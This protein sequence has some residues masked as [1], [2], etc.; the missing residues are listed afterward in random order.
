MKETREIS[1]NCRRSVNSDKQMRVI[2][3]SSITA[4]IAALAAASAM[5][6][7]P[8]KG[9]AVRAVSV[10]GRPVSWRSGGTLRT[11]PSPISLL[12]DFGAAPGSNWAPLRMRYKLEGWD[13]DWQLG[14]GYM[15]LA[16]RFCNEAG[17]KVAQQ[18]FNVI[19]KAR[20][21]MAIPRL[22]R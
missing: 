3:R 16:I 17:D 21:G 14:G 13:H 22:R 18:A 6:Q 2:I 8:A 12:L 9:L 1:G 15:F 20:A 7:G 10:D 4:V 5:A 11:K 19:G